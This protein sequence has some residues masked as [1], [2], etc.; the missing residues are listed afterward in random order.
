MDGRGLAADV[1]DHVEVLL[2][3]PGRPEHLPGRGR[4]PDGVIGQR[5]LLVP[6]R[7]V[8]V[9]LRRAAWLFL[10][11]PGAEQVGEQ[12]VIT[13]PAAHLIQRDQEQPGPFRLLEQR[14]AASRPVTA[15]HNGPLSRSSIE[16]SSR[17]VRSCSSCRSSTSSAR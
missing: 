1:E 6:G 3:D 11:Q 7:G 8:A 15:S 12:V 2:D 17:N 13:P 10:L 14:L 16:V 9:Q 5:V 4:V